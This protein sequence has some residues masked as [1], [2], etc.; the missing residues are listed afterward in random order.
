MA[1]K[2]A[3]F[4]SI[5]SQ[6]VSKIISFISVVALS[7]L[8]SPAELGVFA[9]AASVAFIASEFKNLGAGTFIIREK[10][11]TD[12]VK[13]TCLLVS[14]IMSFGIAFIIWCSADFVGSFYDSEKLSDVLLILSCVFL[15]SPFTLVPLA[16]LTKQLQFKEIAVYNFARQAVELSV[17]ITLILNDK[18]IYSIAYGLVV[19]EIIALVYVY[20]VC[21]RE[22]FIIPSAKN[23]TEIFSFGFSISSSNFISRLTFM[24]PDFIIGKIGTM[25]D[26][27]YFS[28]AQGA[29]NFI[30]SALMAG[31][32]PLVTPYL[33]RSDGEKLTN[34][35]VTATRYQIQ[36]IWPILITVALY[37]QE[38]VMI[39]FGSQ[40]LYSA[41]L[42]PFLAIAYIIRG[43]SSSSSPIFVVTRRQKLWL[44]LEVF[45]FSLTIAAIT[46][47]YEYGLIYISY[48]YAIISL[49]V[50]SISLNLVGNIL[51]LRITN[52]I[53]SLWDIITVNAIFLIAAS[54]LKIYS[55]DMEIQW[56][57]ILNALLLPP[58]YLILLKLFEI[59]IYKEIVQILGKR[60]L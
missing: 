29:L 21:K 12:D 6:L 20:A 13:R 23:I 58:F 3:A 14:M 10:N 32:E 25:A 28:R 37:P 44:R 56:V 52:L 51:N 48:A 27:A 15:L 4:Y 8:L 31:I 49:I 34:S 36:V 35:F 33:A 26:V 46:L 57:V 9:I 50:T 2:K 40:W 30:K 7:R 43:L 18:G 1:I 39:L 47:L 17:T 60:K 16:M 45:A 41:K 5:S 42:I 54:A 11:I 53:K 24:G 22:F 59:E 55:S 19:A 38:L